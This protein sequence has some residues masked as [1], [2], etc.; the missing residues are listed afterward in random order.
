MAKYSQGLL[1]RAF[2]ALGDSTRRGILEQL[3][4]GEASVSQLAAPFGVSLPTIHEHLRVLEHAGF[5]RHKKRGRVRHVRLTQPRERKCKG[6]LRLD[7]LPLHEV[8]D[9]MAHFEAAWDNSL[10]R[11]KQQVESDYENH[12]KRD[13]H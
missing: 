9:W 6:G 3:S 10:Q 5:I 13:N 12:Q 1:D 11:L 2:S 7:F 4:H 8:K